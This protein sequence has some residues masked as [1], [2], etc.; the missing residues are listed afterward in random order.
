MLGIKGKPCNKCENLFVFS[1]VY[2]E[3]DPCVHCINA[4]LWKLAEIFHTGKKLIKKKK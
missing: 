3:D 1:E 4:D 2:K